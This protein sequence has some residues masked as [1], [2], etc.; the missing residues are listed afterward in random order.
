VTTLI[1]PGAEPREVRVYQPAVGL[2]ETANLV[3]TAD[4]VQVLDGTQAALSSEVTIVNTN[5][6]LNVTEEGIVISSTFDSVTATSDD[7]ATQASLDAGFA[8]LIGLT[9]Y[10]LIA[11]SGALLATESFDQIPGGE[12]ITGSLSGAVSPLPAEPFGVGA[13]WETVGSLESNGV[14][15]VQ[16]STFTVT[17]IQG[18]LVS[19]EIALRQELGPEG[20]TL[21]GLDTADIDADVSTD[22]SGAAVWNLEGVFPVSADSSTTQTLDATISAD[23]QT[24]RLEQVVDATFSLDRL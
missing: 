21:P 22:G 19:V 1:D 24:G 23:G 20:F 4:I 2:S 6:V 5:A 9:V 12:I 15:F 11:P 8:D 10:Q 17:D 7:Q 13:V 3:T 18:P 14:V 16:T